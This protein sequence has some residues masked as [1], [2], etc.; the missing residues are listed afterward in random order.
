MIPQALNETGYM[1]VSKLLLFCFLF[2][3]A[4]PL[5]AFAFHPRCHTLQSQCLALSLQHKIE[6]SCALKDQWCQE[7]MYD[8]DGKFCPSSESVCGL[9]WAFNVSRVNQSSYTS[10]ISGYAGE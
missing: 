2:G 1:F 5:I 4:Q 10:S 3:P 9:Q 8:V 7:G 6:P